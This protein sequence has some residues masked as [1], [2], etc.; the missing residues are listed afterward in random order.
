[1]K[2]SAIFTAF[3]ATAVMASPVDIADRGYPTTTTTPAGY[4]TTTTTTTPAGYPT[5]SSTPPTTSSTPG[6][7]G[8]GYPTTSSSSPGSYPTGGGGSGGSYVPCTGAL[9]SQAQCCATDILGIADLNCA[10]RRLPLLCP[11][12]D[13]VY[14]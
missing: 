7:G 13:Y 6:G 8:G 12:Y 14:M 11:Q 3:L 5:T 4:P 9:Y 10:S 2:Y 1:M